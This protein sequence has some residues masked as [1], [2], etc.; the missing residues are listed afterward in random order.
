MEYSWGSPY[1]LQQQCCS[2]LRKQMQNILGNI[3]T[4]II[5]HIQTIAHKDNSPLQ[6][7]WSYGDVLVVGSGPGGE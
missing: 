6:R 5:D 3:W 2:R 4:W 7:Y 1:V